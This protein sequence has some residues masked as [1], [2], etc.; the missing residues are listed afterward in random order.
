MKGW[1][2]SL[3][4]QFKGRQSI[5][6][7]NLLPLVDQIASVVRRE[8]E[9][10]VGNS[11]HFLLFPLWMWTE[12]PAQGIASSTYK[13]GLPTSVTLWCF[14]VEPI[15]IALVFYWPAVSVTWLLY[16]QPERN[17]D[18]RHLSDTD[19]VLMYTQQK[20]LMTVI[21]LISYDPLYFFHNLP[22][23]NSTIKHVQRFSSVSAQPSW[24]QNLKC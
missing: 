8:I 19:S 20:D 16:L 1:W 23:Y 7:G 24:L 22:I 6:A 2:G 12:T 21:A 18:C 4:L 17:L 11:P 13:T 5:M 9:M 10:N 14:Y 15:H 3:S